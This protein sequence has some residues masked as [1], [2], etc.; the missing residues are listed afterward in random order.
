MKNSC[1]QMMKCFLA[2]KMYTDLIF[3]LLGVLQVTCYDFKIFHDSPGD[4]GQNLWD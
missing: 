3:C 4:G 2:Q 1:S